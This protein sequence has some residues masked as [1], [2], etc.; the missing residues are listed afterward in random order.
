MKT[1]Y[2][3]VLIAAISILIYANSLNNAF[4]YDDQI[5][6]EENSNL[7]TIGPWDIFL[8][9]SNLFA[10]N[11]ATGHY[12]PLVLLIH[13]VNYRVHGLKPW[14]YH[15]VN[16][17]FHMGSVMLLFLIIRAMSGS[18]EQVGG[19]WKN[20]AEP[21]GSNGFKDSP[22]TLYPLPA[23]FLAL[24]TALIFA[25][26]PF[27][28]EVINYIT[29]R[30]SVMS[31]FFY[32]LAFYCWVRYRGV[33]WSRTYYAAS[34]AAF[35]LGML[36]KEVVIT[37]PIV[38]WLYDHYF[39]HPLRAPHS[40]LRTLLSWRTYLPYFPFVVAVAVPMM[41]MRLIYWGGVMPSFRR[42]LWVQ[43]FT[44]LPVLVK[45]LRLFVFPV[46]LNVDHY[47]EIYQVFF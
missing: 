45:H 43:L 14:G 9:P 35:L 1:R 19:S 15:V 17:V 12:R 26:H 16:L 34:L 6:L 24:T 32:L 41:I 46:G 30:S 20:Q 29:A 27:N 36:S 33:S 21:G 7:R 18:G 13:V 10:P 39:V 11:T 5:Y 31:G 40:A 44:E 25:V 23:T 3:V 42:P 37:L 4:H 22:A 38:L 47:Q 28:S 2:A 8:N